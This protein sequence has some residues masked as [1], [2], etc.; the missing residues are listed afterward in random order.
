MS[1]G[2]TM[3]RVVTVTPSGWCQR[4]KGVFTPLFEVHSSLA[5]CMSVS[6]VSEP[7][8]EN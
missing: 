6:S 1:V 2:I 3:R 5:A 7:C 4:E 8:S